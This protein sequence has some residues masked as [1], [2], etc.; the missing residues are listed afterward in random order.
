MMTLVQF[1]ALAF[2]ALCV[3]ASA[4]VVVTFEEIP[5]HPSNFAVRVPT[6]DPLAFASPL[7][8]PVCI[9]AGVAVMDTSELYGHIDLSASG[10][11]GG[12][13]SDWLRISR[14]G[15]GFFDF[16]SAYFGQTN[17]TSTVLVVVEG[18]SEGSLLHT[19]SLGPS[20]Q[21]ASL[22]D[23]G[24]ANVD[25][26][27]L[28]VFNGDGYVTIDDIAV[29]VSEVPA[30]G[31]LLLVMTGMALVSRTVPRAPGLKRRTRVRASA[32]VNRDDR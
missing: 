17:M 29:S 1:A 10:P 3:N 24:W 6:L 28:R 27:S 16:E 4:S 19:T 31:T 8:D 22:V 9:D 18:Y 12:I 23:F 7:C 14:I 15:G 26:V 25:L 13:L 2:M 32:P 11:M 20:R 5:R 21:A 30:P